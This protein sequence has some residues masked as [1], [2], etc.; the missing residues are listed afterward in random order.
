MIFIGRFFIAET[1]RFELSNELPRCL[2]SKQVPSTTQPRLQYISNCH[3]F[4][5]RGIAVA[6]LA[7]L[8]EKQRAVSVSPTQPRLQIVYTL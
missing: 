3:P 2:F 7:L 6:T 1:E 5:K 8:M 4:G